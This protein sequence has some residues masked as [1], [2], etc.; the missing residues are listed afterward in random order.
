[1]AA[2]CVC[3]HAPMSKPASHEPLAWSATE[4]WALLAQCREGSPTSHDTGWQVSPPPCMQC[5]SDLRATAVAE[6]EGWS[7][8]SDAAVC[9]PC[10]C[11]TRATA[12]AEWEE[13]CPQSD[14]AAC[15]PCVHVARERPLLHNGRGGVRNRTQ[16]CAGYAHVARER[17][18]L[19]NGRMVRRCMCGLHESDAAACR[20][21]DV[22]IMLW[23]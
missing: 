15:G 3:L 18:L 2:C 11:S 4:E 8:Q 17:S 20:P 23:P 22:H 6:W 1:M 9:G 14:A 7:P 13:W 16:Q 21:C 19:Q 5:E 10:A 12:V